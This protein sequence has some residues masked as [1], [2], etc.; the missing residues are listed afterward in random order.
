M[1]MPMPMTKERAET[2]AKL[3]PTNLTETDLRDLVLV[4]LDHCGARESTYDRVAKA[5]ADDDR[6]PAFEDFPG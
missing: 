6:I 4:C 5:M 2:L 3:L 1:K